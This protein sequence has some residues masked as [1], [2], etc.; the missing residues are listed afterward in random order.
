MSTHAFSYTDYTCRVRQYQ[1][2]MTQTQDTSTSMRFM[3]R[4]ETL[5]LSYAGCVEKSGSDSIYHF[6]PGQFGT[7]DITFKTQDTIDLPEKLTGTIYVKGN[8]FVLWDKLE[9][10]KY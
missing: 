10:T 4:H 8:F 5:A 1:V 6:Y 2:D 3:D 7:I 9:C